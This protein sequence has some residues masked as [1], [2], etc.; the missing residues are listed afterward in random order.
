VIAQRLVL[1]LCLK[2][3]VAGHLMMPRRKILRPRGLQDMR[4][5]GPQRRADASAAKS[6]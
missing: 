6:G 3:G 4:K 2:G 1:L 5:L